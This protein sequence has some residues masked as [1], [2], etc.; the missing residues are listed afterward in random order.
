MRKSHRESEFEDSVEEA[1]PRIVVER[2]IDG[3]GS[4]Y[5]QHRGVS[6]VTPTGHVGVCV[7]GMS[8]LCGNV[9]KDGYTN[10]V[11]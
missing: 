5:L 1:C 8:P 2:V 6:L 3:R 10:E 4:L 11:S 9:E 7:L